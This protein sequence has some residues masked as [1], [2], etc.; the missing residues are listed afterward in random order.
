MLES[1]PWTAATIA[2]TARNGVPGGRTAFSPVL[3]VRSCCEKTH[4]SS[5]QVCVSHNTQTACA[6]GARVFREK[7]AAL[8]FHRSHPRHM[9]PAVLFYDFYCWPIIILQRFTR[10]FVCECEYESSVWFLLDQRSVQICRTNF[11][12][13]RVTGPRSQRVPHHQKQSLCLNI[14]VRCEIK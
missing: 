11:Y 8:R 7:G 5:S 10:C 9:T 1:Y 14:A 13:Y 6:R 12:Q 3:V 4:K 2:A